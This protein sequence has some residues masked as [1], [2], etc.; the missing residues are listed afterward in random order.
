MTP[1]GIEKL[2]PVNEEKVSE[3]IYFLSYRKEIDYNSKYKIR[4]NILCVEV[5]V[6]LSENFEI[7]RN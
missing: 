6:W 2:Y 1:V 5:L 7:E 4:G 3:W